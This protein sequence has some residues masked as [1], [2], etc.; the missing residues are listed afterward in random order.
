MVVV[1][2]F[3]NR[4]GAILSSTQ[5]YDRFSRLKDDWELIK[6]DKK[7]ENANY[8]YFKNYLKYWVHV[9]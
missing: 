6:N 1:F 9:D 7:K 2:S 4:D 8:K 3:E 5:Y